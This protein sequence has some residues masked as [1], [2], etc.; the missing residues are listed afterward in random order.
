MGIIGLGRIGWQQMACAKMME[1]LRIVAGVEPIDKNAALLPPDVRRYQHWQEL[2]ADREL[3]AISICTPHHL[4]APMALAAL[5]AGKHVLA[6]KPLGL[7]TTEARQVIAAA[8]DAGRVLMVE[9]T[10][11]FY[12]PIQ[13]AMQ[14][15]QSGKMG[16]IFAVEDRIIEPAGGQIQSWLTQKALAGGGVALTNGIHMLD[17]IAAVLGRPL[18]LVAGRAHD[19]GGLGNIEDSAAMLLTTEDGVSV[20]FLAAWPRGNGGCDDELTVYGSRGTLRVWAWRGWR[21][22]PLDTQESPRQHD[23][24]SSADDGEARVRVGVRGALQ[25]FV[26]AIIEQRP[27][28]PSAADALAAQEIVEQCYQSTGLFGGRP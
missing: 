2:I 5:K 1:G 14:W 16:T 10:H 4:H 7:T 22:E 26:S 11:R 27:P 19:G 21:F 9:L 20:Q 18:H 12:P 3:D 24:Y 23:C 6:E 13:Q 15:V 17:R 28:R 25:E 8:K